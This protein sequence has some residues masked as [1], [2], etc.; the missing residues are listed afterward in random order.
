MHFLNYAMC[1]TLKLSKKAHTEAQ[2][3]SSLC[4]KKGQILH[5]NSC[6]MW[7]TTTSLSSQGTQQI[8]LDNCSKFAL[9]SNIRLS[10]TF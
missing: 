9:I 10:I 1:W 8:K 6:G 5:D 4:P 7:P 3:A 2:V